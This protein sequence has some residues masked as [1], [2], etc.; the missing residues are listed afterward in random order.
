MAERTDR[1]GPA[2]T[3]TERR[4]HQETDINAGAVVWFGIVLAAVVAAVAIATHVGLFVADRRPAAGAAERSPL[5]EDR[6]P[7][8]PRL[9]AAPPADMRAFRA[10][11][12]A[13]LTSSGWVDQANGVAHIPIE[14]AKKLL[15]EQG[16]P[17]APAASASAEKTP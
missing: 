1:P 16:L 5:A 11:E 15:L 8:A 3:T 9:Q 12:D 6:L 10:H 4:A 17:V 14:Q 7:P 13:I 2:T